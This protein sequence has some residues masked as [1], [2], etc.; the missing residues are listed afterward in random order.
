MTGSSE[1]LVSTLLGLIVLLL[2]GW[3]LRRGDEC[4]ARELRTELHDGARG[5]R[6]ELA[7]SRSL[8]QRAL[9][10]QGGDVARTHNEQTDSFCVQLAA[11]QQQVS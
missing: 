5:T 3:L 6:Q 7:G 10:A 4:P 2:L 8:F 9:L 1:W 11:I